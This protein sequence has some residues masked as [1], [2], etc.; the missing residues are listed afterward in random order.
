MKSLFKNVVMKIKPARI[1][2]TNNKQEIYEGIKI[3][4][5]CNSF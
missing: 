2:K 4:P 3:K 1:G 5:N